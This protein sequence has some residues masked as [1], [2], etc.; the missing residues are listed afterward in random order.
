MGLWVGRRLQQVPVLQ[1]SHAQVSTNILQYTQP[2]IQY[3]PVYSANDTVLS[4]ILSQWYSILQY[5]RPMVQ[6]SPVY[7]TMQACTLQPFAVGMVSN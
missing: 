3:S 1:R 4:S 2:M 7:S 6:Y 5:T